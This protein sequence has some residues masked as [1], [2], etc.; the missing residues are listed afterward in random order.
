MQYRLSLVIAMAL[1]DAASLVM[2][3]NDVGAASHALRLVRLCLPAWLFSFW[4]TVYNAQGFWLCLPLPTVPIPAVFHSASAYSK[5][6]PHICSSIPPESLSNMSKLLE[7]S[8][9]RYASFPCSL[10]LIVVDLDA[11]T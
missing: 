6:S 8:G 4:R 11:R 2:T 9:E 10:S 7:G 3:T 1:Y 5:L